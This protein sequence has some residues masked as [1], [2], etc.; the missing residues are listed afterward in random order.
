MGVGVTVHAVVEHRLQKRRL[1]VG[2]RAK[3]LPGP[4]TDRPRCGHDHA[5]QRL[6]DQP[7]FAAVVQPQRV[8]LLAAGQ[9]IFYMQH[10]ARDLQ[11]GQPRARILTDFEHTRAEF[12]PPGRGAGQRLQAAQQPVQPVQPQRRAEKH[13][14]HLPPRNSGLHGFCRCCAGLKH[15]VHQRLAAQS[16]RL[17][18]GRGGKIHA[19]VPEPPAQLPQAHGGVRAGQV[20]LVDKYKRRYAITRQQLPQCLGVGLHAVGAGD[21]Q[22]RVIQHLQSALGLGG[23]IHVAGRIQ[24][25]QLGLVGA[26]RGGQRQHGLLGKD[27]DAPRPLLAVGIKKGVPVVHAPQLAQHP[28]AVKQPFG[29]CSFAAVHMCQQPDDQTFHTR[30]P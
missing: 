13:R 29:Q 12:R 7:E 14:E 11:P 23:K 6:A 22:H 27:R 24:Q 8:G 1:G 21:D 15:L 16:Q 18:V 30:S 19:P 26:V 9:H 4:R 5:G 25:R 10:A 2:F 20:H 3:P 28:R 17:R